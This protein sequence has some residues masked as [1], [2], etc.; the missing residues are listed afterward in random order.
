[1]ERGG[2]PGGGGKYMLLREKK[3]PILCFGKVDP[4]GV[5]LNEEK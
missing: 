3:I 2:I 4:R 5:L 1:M